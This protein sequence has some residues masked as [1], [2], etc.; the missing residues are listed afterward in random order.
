[1]RQKQLDMSLIQ[2]Y[3]EKQL[4]VDTSW[5]KVCLYP[6]SLE[7]QESQFYELYGLQQIVTSSMMC[8]RQ[9]CIYLTWKTLRKKT[10][11]ETLAPLGTLF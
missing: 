9:T 11:W 7:K 2:N 3:E 4:F 8:V 6:N 10:T 1:M 5:Q